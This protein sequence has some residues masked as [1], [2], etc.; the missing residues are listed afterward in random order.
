MRNNGVMNKP[1]SRPQS[2]LSIFL[3]ATLLLGGLCAPLGATAAR[4]APVSSAH[5]NS[6]PTDIQG[7]PEQ[8]AMSLPPAE[9]SAGIAK[10][11][12]THMQRCQAS[13]RGIKGASAHSRCIHNC[14]SR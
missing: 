14:M 10:K 13:C 12:P 2:R 5:S 6:Q 8:E 11:P 7:E 1:N 9:A 3:V 4:T